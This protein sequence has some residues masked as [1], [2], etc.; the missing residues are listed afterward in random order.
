MILI[1]VILD[2]LTGPQHNLNTR[3]HA[4]T[5]DIP[6]GKCML[7]NVDIMLTGHQHMLTVPWDWDWDPWGTLPSPTCLLGYPYDILRS[8]Q[9]AQTI[10][11][12]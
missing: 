10:D 7:A 9:H 6:W 4:Q 8:R 11:I 3:Q 5:I 12:P 1:R 2:M